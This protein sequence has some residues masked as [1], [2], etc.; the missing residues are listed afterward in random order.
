MM[1]KLDF[2][3]QTSTKRALHITT[4]DT[5]KNKIFLFSSQII[6]PKSIKKKIIISPPPNQYSMVYKI[7]CLINYLV[8]NTKHNI[9]YELSFNSPLIPSQRVIVLY[10]CNITH[11]VWPSVS[12]SRSNWQ[13]RNVSKD[14][15][16][17]LD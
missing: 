5:T 8:M 12:K 2:S 6:N 16:K 14:T 10:T 3:N 17:L 4:I 15:T 11:A 7:S 13:Y 1:V 9:R